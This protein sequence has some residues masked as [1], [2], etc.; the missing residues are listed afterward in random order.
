MAPSVAAPRIKEALTRA[1]EIDADLAEG[2]AS[3]GLMKDRFEWDGAGAE[4]EFRRASELNANYPT[5]HHW[6]ANFLSQ[7]KR[8]DEAITESRLAQKLDPLS[9]IINSVLALTLLTAGKYDSAGG[10]GFTE[11]RLPK[12]KKQRLILAARRDT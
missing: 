1:L 2:H 5:T 11:K 10:R 9:P 8:N 4:K 7:R 12:H 3:L 6:Y